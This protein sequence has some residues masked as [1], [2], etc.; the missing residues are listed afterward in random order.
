[1]CNVMSVRETEKSDLIIEV[2]LSD[3][4]AQNKAA[5][6]TRMRHYPYGPSLDQQ[7]HPAYN[8]RFV[9]LVRRW[10]ESAM[11]TVAMV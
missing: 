1:M 5:I 6:S 3:L 4:L 11:R 10:N 9:Q 8:L 7:G 2:F